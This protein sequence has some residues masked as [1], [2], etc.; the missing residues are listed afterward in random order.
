MALT[1][2]DIR[3]FCKDV[4]EL[5]ILLEGE[6]QSSDSLITRAIRLTVSDFNS[7]PPATQFSAEDFPSDSTLLFGVQH[8]LALAEAERQLRNQV[9]FAA[10]G[11]NAG[12]DDKHQQYLQLAGTYRQ[13]FLDKTREHKVF[14]NMQQ[15]WGEVYSPY[16][17]INEHRFKNG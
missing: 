4:P 10:Q 12:I 17:G 2:E 6:V 15:A 8:Y 14:I 11:V 9:N 3:E 7:Y 13:F 5:N 1:V 16:V